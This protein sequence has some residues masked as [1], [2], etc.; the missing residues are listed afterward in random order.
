MSEYHSPLKYRISGTQLQVIEVQLAEG[1]QVFSETGGMVWMDAN[2]EMDTAAPNSGGGLLGA[3]GG[4]ISRAVSGVGVFLNYFKAVGGEGRVAFAPALPGRVVDVLLAPGQSIIAQ[5]GAFLVGEET[6]SLK[7]E[8]VR[9]IGAGLF[10]GE[11]FILQ[12]I[13]G[14]GHAFLEIAG[15][16]T[17]VDLEPGQRLRV[18]AGHVAGFT[19]TVAYDIEFLRNIKMMLFSGEGLALA[20]LTGPGRVWLQHMT[21]GGLAHKLAPYMPKSG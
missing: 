2:I 9:R 1:H 21:I 17:V 15:E 5:R 14:P 12:R 16:L 18:H 20:V 13:S 6:L 10:G 19:E 11:G 4:A 3:V 8:F 7:V